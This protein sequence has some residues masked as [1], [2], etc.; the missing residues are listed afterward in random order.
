MFQE[1]WH[2][3]NC[4]E[5]FCKN[6]AVTCYYGCFSGGETAGVL[7]PCLFPTPATA[8][9]DHAPT[10]SPFPSSLPPGAARARALGSPSGQ[11]PGQ[12]LPPAP[13]VGKQRACVTAPGNAGGWGS[14]HPGS[15]ACPC[16][17][18]FPTRNRALHPSRRGRP[19]RHLPATGA[20]GARGARGALA[21]GPA[22][23]PEPSPSTV[24]PPGRGWAGRRL[25]TCCPVAPRRS[26]PGLAHG[27]I[28][29]PGWRGRGD[30]PP[31]QRIPSGAGARPRPPAAP[32]AAGVGSRCPVPCA[33]CASPAPLRGLAKS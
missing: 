9:F 19:G 1:E 18:L 33:G 24:E 14:A 31:A 13:R 8:A 21:A 5:L 16:D 2:N 27:A 6:V 25:R 23:L 17:G 32:P 29:S 15:G 11:T 12:L 3:H 20:R 4:L 26:V 22:P 10:T 28:R 30:S 7:P